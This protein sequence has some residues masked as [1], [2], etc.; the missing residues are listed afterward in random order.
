MGNPVV[1][2]D[3]DGTVQLDDLDLEQRISRLVLA[4][5]QI[6]GEIPQLPYYPSVLSQDQDRTLEIGIH[7]ICGVDSAPTVSLDYPNAAVISA[8]YHAALDSWNK[9]F[10]LVYGDLKGKYLKG[11]DIHRPEITPQ[12]IKHAESLEP[13]AKECL[14]RYEQ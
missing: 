3:S 1:I 14:E 8:D 7:G 6:V 5:T 4:V 13:L 2:P 10:E 11:F 9:R 12:I